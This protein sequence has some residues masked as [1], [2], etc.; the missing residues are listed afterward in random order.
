MDKL[1]K[2]YDGSISTLVVPLPSFRKRQKRSRR[3]PTSSRVSMST[4]PSR[5]N[6]LE[7]STCWISTYKWCET[8]RSQTASYP[9]PRPS[10]PPIPTMNPEVVAISAPKPPAAQ[11]CSTLLKSNNYR[12]KTSSTLIGLNNWPSSRKNSRRNAWLLLK[13]WE[14]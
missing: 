6:C 13:G 7:R 14:H 11:W 5:T 9:A 1:E 3:R 12:R 10:S 2:L 4:T 8:P